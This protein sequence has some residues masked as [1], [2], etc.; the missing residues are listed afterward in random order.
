MGKTDNDRSMTARLFDSAVRIAFRLGYPAM[1]LVWRVFKPHHTGVGVLI[2]H[3]DQI[4]A[5]RHSYRPG[6][7]IPGGGMN[8]RES[9]RQT[10]VREL[11]EELSIAADPDHLVYKRHI[12]NTYLFELRLVERPA[13]R[14]DHREI[15]E[16][17]FMSP[18][19]AMRLDPSFRQFI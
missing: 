19:E 8:R 1:C 3:D 16:A 14:I 18:E 4:L 6:F 5:V 15:V 12:Y 7:T 13:I 11:A 2:R 17:L 9:P 10:A